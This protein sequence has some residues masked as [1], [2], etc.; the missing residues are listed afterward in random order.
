M[1]RQ[2]YTYSCDIAGKC[3]KTLPAH[4]DPVSAVHFNRDGSLI[5]RPTHLFCNRLSLWFCFSPRHAMGYL[6]VFPGVLFIIV[7]QSPHPKRP[8]SRVSVFLTIVFCISP[9]PPSS[10]SSFSN[11]VQWGASSVLVLTFI[12][13]NTY[14]DNFIRKR[15][16]SSLYNDT[17]KR[18]VLWESLSSNQKG[19]GEIRC[20]TR[21]YYIY[22]FGGSCKDDM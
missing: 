4:S 19:E 5:G 13:K 17:Q 6:L 18:L 10:N 14:K 16:I 20:L 9:P 1:M 2:L 12:L 7:F 15:V 11:I 3:L 8:R 21:V 22:F